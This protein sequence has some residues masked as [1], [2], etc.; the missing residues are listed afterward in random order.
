MR[1]CE[2][3]GGLGEEMI[4]ASMGIRKRRHRLPERDTGADVPP[5]P[6]CVGACDHACE[7][8]CRSASVC[9]SMCLCRSEEV[10]LWKDS[11]YMIVSGLGEPC[12]VEGSQG[13]WM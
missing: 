13:S 3:G 2:A 6:L 7:D 8:V 4:P 12:V 1:V 5:V 11:M 10:Y 9:R